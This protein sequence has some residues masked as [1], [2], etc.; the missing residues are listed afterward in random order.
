M[1]NPI[2]RAEALTLS[3]IKLQ[4]VDSELSQEL[5]P[6]ALEEIQKIENKSQLIVDDSEKGCSIH[7]NGAATPTTK[8]TER[9]L[10]MS[11]M[12]KHFE[13]S[14]RA[15]A[16]HLG[17]EGDEALEELEN[18]EQ[19]DGGLRGYGVSFE[20]DGAE[21]AVL[22]EEDADLAWDE[23]LEDYIDECVLSDLPEVAR[24]YFDRE[25]WK[26]DAKHDGRG[27]ALNSYDGGEDEYRV[28]GHWF[29]IYRT[30]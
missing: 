11:N 10:A 7:I 14:V 12:K 22:D 9:P 28:G 5:L 30:N 13:D 19:V 1:T 25:A 4:N 21:Y 23:C 27:H 29:F 26:R 2:E 24:T 15:M 3:A 6:I 17:I 8:Q 20:H 18:N 16:E